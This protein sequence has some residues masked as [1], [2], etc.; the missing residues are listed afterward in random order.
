MKKTPNNRKDSAD[1]SGGGRS[2]TEIG[3]LQAAGTGDFDSGRRLEVLRN[4]PDT[5]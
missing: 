3:R 4:L 5:Q 2:V 1:K